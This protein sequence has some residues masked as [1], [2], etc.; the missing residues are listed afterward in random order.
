L[1]SGRAHFQTGETSPRKAADNAVKALFETG[2]TISDPLCRTY[3]KAAEGD[4]PDSTLCALC[5][6]VV[7]PFLRPKGGRRI[8]GQKDAELDHLSVYQI[9]LSNMSLRGKFDKFLYI[10][11][12]CV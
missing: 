9:F 10:F 4:E 7:S 2:V 3:P 5:V 11:D 8:A 12:D 1:L 6:S